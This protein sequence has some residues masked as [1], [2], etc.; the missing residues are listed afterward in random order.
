MGEQQLLKII[1][2][3]ERTY[4]ER[5]PNSIGDCM[6]T[7]LRKGA[8]KKLFLLGGGI[9]AHTFIDA[10]KIIPDKPHCGVRAMKYIY[11]PSFDL[12]R[13]FFAS[14]ALLYLAHLLSSRL[15]FLRNR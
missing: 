5:T 6:H 11:F 12:F 2:L 1:A 10:S 15:T 3:T 8:S 7:L 4:F 14:H 9:V 13:F